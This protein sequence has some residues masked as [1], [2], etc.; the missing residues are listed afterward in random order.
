[1]GALRFDKFGGQIPAVDDRLLPMENSAYAENAFLQAGALEPLAA[2]VEIHECTN[3]KIRSVFRVPQRPVSIN[4]IGSTGNKW[5]EFEDDNTTVVRSPVTNTVD[6]GRFYWASSSGPPGYTTYNRLFAGQPNLLLGIPS[7]VTA[8]TVGTVVGGSAPTVTRAY[9][10]TWVNELGEE[11]GPSPPSLLATGNY[12]GTWPITVTAPVPA[13]FVNRLPPTK[14]RIYRTEV[15]T[16]GLTVGYFFVVELPVA[17]LTFGDNI[18]GD[19]VNQSEQLQSDD[20]LPPPTDLQGLASMANGM[21]AGWRGNEVWFCEPY[22]PHA[23]PVKYTINVDAR[24]VG[25]GTIDQNLMILT[26][27]WPYVAMGIHPEIVSLRKVQ[28]LEPC[29]SQGSIVSTPQGVLYTSHNGLILIGPAGGKNL[30]FD[31]I[32]KDDWAKLF[33]LETVH[34][35]YMMNGY[36]A[37]SGA[38]QDVFQTDAFQI[39]DEPATVDEDEAAF[40]KEDYRG[41]R[42]GAHINLTDQRLGYMTLKSVDVTYNVLPDVWTGETIVIR[43]SS[44]MVEL[45]PVGAPGVFTSVPVNRVYHVDRRSYNPRQS[46]LWRSKIVQ[47]PFK[48]N[49]AAAKVYFS[50]PLGAPPDDPRGVPPVEPTVFRYYADGRLKLTYPLTEGKSGKQFRLPSGFK[51]DTVQFELQGQ[52]MI[53]NMQVATSARELRTV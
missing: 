15:A 41:T 51:A 21:I 37:F 19:V 12:D 39:N 35:T 6:G 10:Y 1:M 11:S 36:Y 40:Q 2:D 42:E 4:T 25:L 33:N 20:W 27:G 9:L 26:E 16:D 17:T 24:I 52:F 28:A 38:G 53:F 30:T 7:P 3:G 23:W 48:E 8:P 22:R 47:T 5:L 31:V 18:P 29:T 46:Y 49:F 50:K 43:G 32:R 44:K 45:D 13:T 14:T 34:A